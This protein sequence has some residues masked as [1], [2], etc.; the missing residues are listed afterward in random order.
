MC[1]TQ[2]PRRNRQLR[3]PRSYLL[4][5]AAGLILLALTL[6][7]GTTASAQKVQLK[8]GRI[9]AGRMMNVTGVAKTPISVGAEDEENQATPILLVHD[10]LRRVY[11]SK[12]FLVRVLDEGQER[13]ITFKP[14][15]NTSESGRGISRVGPSLGI[16][17]FDE[18]GRRIFRMQTKDGPLSVVQAITELTPHYTKVETWRGH[19]QWDMRLRTS[20][21]P[22]DKIASILGQIVSQDDPDDWLRV[23]RFYLQSDR[24]RDA[25]LELEAIMQRFPEKK[26][27][28][29]VASQLKQMGANRI[30]EEMELLSEAGQHKLVSELLNNFPPEEVAGE[31]LQRVREMISDYQARQTRLDR[32]KQVMQGMVEG[33]ADPGQREVIQP[34]VQE[35]IEELSYN[36]SERLVPFLQLVEDHSL[37][38]EDKLGLA[39][40]GWV[41]G[42]EGAQQGIA[43][44]VS[45]VQVRDMV[46]KYLREKLVHERHS[47][48]DNMRSADGASVRNLARLIAH[49]KPPWEIPE[50]SSQGYGAYQLTAKGQS[51]NGDFQYVVQL[52][53]EYDPY[54]RYPTIL[55]LNGAYNT[56]EQEL[57]FWT[58]GH[59]R[60]EAGEMIGPRRG[61]AMRHG[62][63]TIAVKWQKPQQ[64][65]Y[66]Y[67]LREHE[68]VLTCLRDAMRRFSIDADRVYLSGHGIGGDAAWDFGLAHPDL[69]AG[70]LPFVAQHSN[71][72][73]Y[74]QH[75]WENAAFV[76]FYFVAGEKD[77]NR[78]VKSAAVLDK[79]F[80]KRFDTTVVEY[81]GRGYESFHDEIH[82]AFSWMALTTHRRQA[83]PEEFG[84]MTMRPWDNFFW[85][86]EGRGFPRAVQPAEWPLRNARPSQ[87][88][89]RIPKKNVLIARTA[90]DE[91]TFWLSPDIVD[92]SKPIRISLNGRTLGE[93]FGSTQPD[94]E[95]LLEDVRTRGD[96]LRPFWAKLQVP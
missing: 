69:W 60:D 6:L 5:S 65:E 12:Y 3:N 92:F 29:V 47:L 28:Q 13:L 49:M 90:C 71:V 78:L 86:I 14:W 41:L 85:W 82:E 19:P 66:E 30:L 39:V 94:M 55:A 40:S 89:G 37:S 54:R 61:Q 74:V 81:L 52:P 7:E 11:V 84:C 20:S 16:S 95:V 96:R 36:N 18:F 76:P 57:E 38:V 33:I 80:L 48:L 10:D 46:R 87:I 1:V 77:G 9:L 62:Y 59:V 53:P 43:V 50:G 68:A 72:R 70:V 45:L 4:R 67:T 21:I 51:E 73:K 23:V 31:T 88:Y 8:D 15:Q 27:L 22:R 83:S 93:S 17:P 26:D 42:A 79:Y 2:S 25:R 56:L 91:T 64:A 58:G 63:I 32:T 24:F 44:A 35:I 34:V 75:Y